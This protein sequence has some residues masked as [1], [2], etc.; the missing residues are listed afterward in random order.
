MRF[1]KDKWKHLLH[2]VS[3]AFSGSAK[4]EAREQ[5]REGLWEEIWGWLFPVLLGLTTG[6][7]CMVLLGLWLGG[8]SAGTQPGKLPVSGTAQTQDTDRTNMAV[9]L[10]ANPFRVTPMEIRE[11]IPKEASGDAYVAITGSLANALLRWTMPKVGVLLEDQGKQHLVLLNTSFDVYTLEEVTY[12]YAIFRKGEERVRKDL[13]YAGKQTQ[14]E[15]TTPRGGGV[16]PT[17]GEAVVPVAGITPADPEKGIE[18]AISR[19]TI[20]QLVE[21]PFDEMK[22]VRIRPSDKEPGLQ[23]QWITKDSILNQVGVKKG[24]VVSSIN[25]IAFKN[26]VDITNSMSSL[27]TSDRFDVTILRNG[28]PVTL[29]Y[30]VR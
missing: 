6:W 24:D 1:L 7:F 13:Y 26:M 21:N 11:E 19:E 16:T 8:G 3:S 10:S 18:G 9:F 4:S 15:P 5:V 17:P 14:Q 30:V 29:R 25:G 22:R 28:T 2:K 20:N 23:V 12:L 27:I